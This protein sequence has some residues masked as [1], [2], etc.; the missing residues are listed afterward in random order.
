MQT[1][2]LIFTY[3]VCRP[4]IDAVDEARLLPDLPVGPLQVLSFSLPIW[5]YAALHTLAHFC[6][7]PMRVPR[8]PVLLAPAPRHVYYALLRA[9]LEGKVADQLR[10]A[11]FQSGPCTRDTLRG[12]QR[13]VLMRSEEVRRALVLPRLASPLH[14]FEPN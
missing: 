3:R 10:P 8:S 6:H 12:P 4:N 13:L 5:R 9:W 11:H 1:G 7:P 2:D 14:S